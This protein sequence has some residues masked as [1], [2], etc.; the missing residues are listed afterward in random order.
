MLIYLFV[1]PQ[2]KE[3]NSYIG[4]I[5]QKLNKMHEQQGKYT[6]GKQTLFGF[7]MVNMKIIT[8]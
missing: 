8:L 1:N 6:C 4:R 2:A 7:K 5:Q 3:N